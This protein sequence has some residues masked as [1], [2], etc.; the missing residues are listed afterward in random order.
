ME[1]GYGYRKPDDKKPKSKYL[2]DPGEKKTSKYVRDKNEK[3]P[4][5]KY[6]RN[7][8]EPKEHHYN[9]TRNYREEEEVLE[10]TVSDEI[11]AAQNEE[12]E[13]AKENTQAVTDEVSVEEADTDEA[14]N[15]TIDNSSEEVISSDEGNLDEELETD[16]SNENSLNTEEKGKYNDEVASLF[17][18]S[19]LSKETTVAHVENEEEARRALIIKTIVSMVVLTA[20]SCAFQRLTIKIPYTPSMI[21][22][23][24]SVFFE[25][26]AS[27][28]YGPVFGVLIVVVKNIFALITSN[29]SYA[30]LVSNLVLDSVYVFICGWFYSKRMFALNPK[31]LDKPVNKD[32]R[33]RRILLGGTIATLATTV[34]AFFLTRFVSYP[35][36]VKQYSEHGVDTHFILDLYQA[37]LDS[38]N[39]AYPEV[40][41]SVVTKFE[42]LTQAIFYYNMPFTILK[43]LFVSLLAALIYP[44]ISPYIHFRKKAR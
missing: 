39:S 12:L 36:L 24:F 33:R 31:K 30:T 43:L 14:A 26:I 25:L 32:M 9:L 22:F 34:V 10:E 44:I 37:A 41:S 20:L 35:L 21:S 3:K 13:A 42:N 40:L 17:A 18:H 5:S 16:D 2:R 7:K 23:E 29:S 19:K 27:L 8:Y 1:N 6:I 11:E 28:A 15:G 38:L 4:Q